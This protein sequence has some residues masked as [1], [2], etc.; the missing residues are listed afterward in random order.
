M[1][2]LKKRLRESQAPKLNKVPL[3]K[4]HSAD[5]SGTHTKQWNIGFADGTCWYWWNVTGP[6]FSGTRK[7]VR[8]RLLNWQSWETFGSVFGKNGGRCLQSLRKCSV[9]CLGIESCL[10]WV[11]GKLQDAQVTA[12][13][14]EGVENLPQGRVT[15]CGQ[16]IPWYLQT[17]IP[18]SSHGRT[19]R[20][21]NQVQP[22]I[23]DTQMT[24]KY[25]QT[26]STFKTETS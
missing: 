16:V 26:Q 13:D 1:R 4:A 10:V 5:P 9:Y 17:H 2:N 18:R 7:N 25:N 11:S 19:R 20:K 15:V 3:L 23:R 12:V 6:F 21:I 14:M 24:L 22:W 8:T